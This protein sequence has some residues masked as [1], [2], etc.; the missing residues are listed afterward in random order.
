MTQIRVR[1]TQF[2]IES[3]KPFGISVANVS[4]TPQEIQVTVAVDGALTAFTWEGG[5]PTRSHPLV[6]ASGARVAARIGDWGRPVEDVELTV[7]AGDGKAVRWAEG[8]GAALVNPSEADEPTIAAAATESRAA[9]SLGER[10]LT[11]LRP[12]LEAVPAS[13]FA[14][15]NTGLLDAGRAALQLTT[16]RIDGL[17]RNELAELPER[18]FDAGALEQLEALGWAAVTLELERKKSRAQATS[19]KLPKPLD[20]ESSER[21]ARMLECVS[22]HLH[23]TPRW[24]EE[25]A[26]IR[27]GSGHI[28][29]A[30]DL[31]RLAD[32]YDAEEEALRDDRKNYR[33]GDAEAARHNSE[34]IFL[35]LA[36]A[37]FS[38]SDLDLEQRVWT[39]LASTYDDVAKTLAWIQRKDPRFVPIPALRAHARRRAPSGPAPTPVPTPSS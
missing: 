28:D 22:Y 16:A 36:K 14:V 4:T 33:P 27:G 1:F 35:E 19:A 24:G 30:Q 5:P 38:R 7:V 12:A 26:D 39:L 9:G 31:A 3:G 21:R 18:H 10:A 29:R 2:K 23:D 17:A 15:R 25:I 20:A 11:L 13:A 34:A 37:G 6:L 8:A 32:I